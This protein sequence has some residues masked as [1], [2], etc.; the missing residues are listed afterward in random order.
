GFDDAIYAGARL[1]E[2]LSNVDDPLSVFAAL[3]KMANTP[4]IRIECPDEIKFEVVERFKVY[5]EEKYPRFVDIDGVRF[6]K[7]DAWGLVRPS[8]TQPVI[9]LRFEAK[10]KATLEEIEGDTRTK[11]DQI[12]R[13][14]G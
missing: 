12:M 7:D 2:V 5:A 13:E 4:E 1:I 6:E 3:T 9:V 10:D 14:I 8:N 11:L